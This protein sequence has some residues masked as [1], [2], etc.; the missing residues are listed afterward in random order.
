MGAAA[1]S[2]SDGGAR[3]RARERDGGG[4]RRRERA[5]EVWG[6]AWQHPELRGGEGEGQAGGVAAMR[7]SGGRV[8]LPP[9][10]ARWTLTGSW[11]GPV[12]GQQVAQV[13]LTLFYISFLFF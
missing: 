11:A 8:P 7:E 2:G 9:V 6:G 1:A 3:V 5:R 12:L 4:E 13:I 10:I